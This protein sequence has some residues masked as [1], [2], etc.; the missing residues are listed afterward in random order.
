LETETARTLVTLKLTGLHAK[1]ND[2]NFSYCRKVIPKLQDTGVADVEVLGEGISIKIIW[3][4]L[5]QGSEPVSVDLATVKCLVDSLNIT[6]KDAK[7]NVLDKIVATLFATWI[8]NSVAQVL[9]NKVVEA[10]EPINAKINEFIRSRPLTQLANKTSEQLKQAFSQGKKIGTEIASAIHESTVGSQEFDYLKHSLELER[11]KLTEDVGEVE[12]RPYEMNLVRKLEERVIDVEKK[13]LTK[14]NENIPKKPQE[15]IP[16]KCETR[17]V[18][19]ALMH[20]TL[21]VGSVGKQEQV[22]QPRI[23]RPKKHKHG[24]KQKKPS[25]PWTHTW[26]SVESTSAE[27]TVPYFLHKEE[28]PTLAEADQIQQQVDDKRHKNQ[29]PESNV[30]IY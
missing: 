3:K 19:E 29:Y 25:N 16:T 10:I 26:S 18:E 1:F 2:V 11:R 24:K 20:K 7:H 22:Q 21:G 12:Q 28:F 6:I 17:N 30:K 8:K 27:S 15:V 5:A 14:A 23:G 9:C 13:L 4:I